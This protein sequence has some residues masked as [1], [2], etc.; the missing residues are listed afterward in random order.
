MPASAAWPWAAAAPAGIL[1]TEQALHDS[2]GGGRHLALAH[3]Y[4]VDAFASAHL[5]HRPQVSD[6][7]ALGGGPYHFLSGARAT[8]RRRA[9]T[10]PIASSAWRSRPR[11]SSAAWRR[12]RPCRRTWPS[13]CTASLPTSRTSG[14][15]R[16]PSHRPPSPAIP[17]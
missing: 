15:D 5:E 9:S 17:R 10:P 1:A 7:L 16:R 12:T 6:S 3:A 8:Q 11:A 13:S 4:I 2:K 14:K